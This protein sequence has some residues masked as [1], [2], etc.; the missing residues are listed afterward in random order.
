MARRVIAVDP[1]AIFIETLITCLEGE[2]FSKTTA[3]RIVGGVRKL[4]NLVA[5]GK[6]EA[7][8][9]T[10]KQNGK[11][12]CNAAQVIRHCRFTRSKKQSKSKSK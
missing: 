11:W 5:E 10:N 3:A 8:K 2:R 9:P 7:D 6:I 12:Y 1:N 4:E